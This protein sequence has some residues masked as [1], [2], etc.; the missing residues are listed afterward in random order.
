MANECCYCGERHIDT[1]MLIL[2][3]NWIE[4][5]EECGSKET[6]TNVETKETI[7]IKQLFDR[8]SAAPIPEM[9]TEQN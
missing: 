7:T 6:V 5:C 2:G 8:L 9:P 4:F 1:S 3:E